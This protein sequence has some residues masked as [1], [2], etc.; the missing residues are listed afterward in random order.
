MQIAIDARQLRQIWKETQVDWIDNF[1]IIQHTARRC[2]TR[3]MKKTSGNASFER[4]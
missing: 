1:G 2:V 3:S 4:G